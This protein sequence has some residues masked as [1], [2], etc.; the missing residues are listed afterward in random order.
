FGDRREEDPDFDIGDSP[1]IYKLDGRTYV[2]AGQK[3]GF[4]HVLDAETGEEVAS[5]I[6]LAP[7]GTVGGLFAD[8]AY[9][10][11]VVFTNG[12]DWPGLLSGEPPN[13]GILSAV[14]ADGS[15]ELWHFDTPFSPNLSAVAVSN[16]VVYFQSIFGTFYALDA[17]SGAPLAQ[18]VTGGL[19][20][21]PAISR[22]QIYLGTG[23]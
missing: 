23:D 17:R 5:P 1:Q 22:G 8:S 13:R 7:D 3:S 10:N 15:H 12:A 11:G 2:S 16:G 9:A 4:F 21:G 6:Q 19:T 20:S 18:V 14:A